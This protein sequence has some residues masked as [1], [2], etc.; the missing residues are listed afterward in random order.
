MSLKSYLKNSRIVYI[1]PASLTIIERNPNVFCAK[2]N[3]AR[4]N[5]MWCN[6]TIRLV[7]GI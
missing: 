6:L 2:R 1:R 4:R 7:S 5:V 3:A